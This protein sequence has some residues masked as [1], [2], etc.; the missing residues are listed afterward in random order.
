VDSFAD[1]ASTVKRIFIRLAAEI[2]SLMVF[3]PVVGGVLGSV[4]MGTVAQQ[5]GLTGGVGIGGGP[6][7]G[8]G[9][10][11]GGF[12]F[13]AL[14]S[15]PSFLPQFAKDALFEASSFLLGPEL[16]SA[17]GVDL[18]GAFNPANALGGFVGSIAANMLGLGHDNALVNAGTGT[19]GGIAGGVIGGPIGAGIGAFLGTALGGLFGPGKSVGPGGGA[20]FGIGG[21]QDLLSFF[22]QGGDNGF[23]ASG[24][25]QTVRQ[26]METL[27]T[28][29]TG[30]GG[31]FRPTRGQLAGLGRFD[32]AGGIF[33][34]VQSAPNQSLDANGPTA[35]TR[36]FG[37]D[38]DAAINDLLVRTLKNFEI[39]G[40]APAVATALANSVATT[41][42]GLV[43]DLD[44]AASLS[45]ITTTVSAFD[46]AMAAVDQRFSE[47][48][49]RARSLGLSIETVTEAQ[50][51]EEEAVR[52]QF[53]AP[54]IQAAEGIA[55]FLRGTEAQ[56]ASP[57]EQLSRMQA[58]FGDLLGRVRGGEVGLTQPLL[59]TAQAL[60]S[61]GRSQFA[62]SVDFQSIDHFVRSQLAS[63]GETLTSEDFFEAQ[64]EAT[65]QQ[66]G[67]IDDGNE[68][69]VSAI[70][71]LRREFQMVRQELAA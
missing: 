62:S 35:V 47:L 27:N 11:G 23:D 68:R 39:T 4:G 30:L 65:R 26:A 2:A 15:M 19:I 61:V 66:T 53:R 48:T 60:T 22:G 32:H 37:S 12:N 40:L 33:S 3:R 43:S 56:F 63:V 67:I 44:F 24:S 46:Q 7:V 10:A 41:F 42:E 34:Q 6:V 45:G 21:G 14:A 55:G 17:F 58:Q 20:Q 51:R 28:L 59:Q 9:A 5:M 57:A 31:A 69:I 13:S 49:D 16:G 70:E 18:V 38:T 64:V 1:L 36:F 8:G 25:A 54:L 71:G 50:R 29:V 52:M